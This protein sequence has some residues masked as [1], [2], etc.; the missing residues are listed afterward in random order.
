[1]AKTLPVIV[2]AFVLM[3]VI[4]MAAQDSSYRLRVDVSMISVDVA[5]FDAAGI[6]V[7]NLSKED[8]EIYEDGRPQQLKSFASLD[9]PYNV[10]LV[11]DQSGSMY[12]QVRFVSE[13]VNRFFSNLRTQDQIALASFNSQVH[14]LVK[15]R[16]VRSG[17]KQVINL[18]AGG[19]T[20]FYGALEWAAKELGKVSGRK[21]VIIFTDGEDYR[22]YDPK[23][24][25]VAFRRALDRVRRTRVPFHFVGLGAD[26]NLGG[27][28]L[29][30]IA[31]ET[32]GHAYFPKK[33]EEVIPLYDQI[34]RELGIS[35]TL[36]YVSDRPAHDGSL[37]N[38]R[39]TVRNKDYRVSQ[40]RTTYLAS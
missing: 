22:I 28:H 24:D 2:L 27:A 39:V 10:L 26:P 20:D 19:N 4:G 35:Y 12:S 11:I 16:S 23:P 7:S 1:M 18:G 8:F 3:S 9:S 5:V 31:Q 25:A 37:R 33:I 15:W 32:G 21:A 38:I 29:T 6:P 14:S 36:G 34:S 30:R 17:S 13:A 40:S